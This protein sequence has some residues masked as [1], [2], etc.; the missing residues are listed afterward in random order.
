[1]PDE[2]TTTKVLTEVE[3]MAGVAKVMREAGALEH[4]VPNSVE[5]RFSL[6]DANEMLMVVDARM[7][8]HTRRG[9]VRVG[10][11]GRSFAGVIAALAVNV[12]RENERAEA[13]AEKYGRAG[14]R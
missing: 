2:R 5:L 1:M 11:F 14:A 9:P 7:D 12:D 6:S 3:V 8:H 13:R 10:G 4:V